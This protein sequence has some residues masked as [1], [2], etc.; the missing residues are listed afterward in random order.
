M[1]EG[2]KRVEYLDFAKGIGVILVIMG[3]MPSIVPN[4]IRM[5]IFSF[6]MP[7]FFVIAGYFA[8]VPNDIEGVI[9]AVRKKTL[10]LLVEGYIAFALCFLGLDIIFLRLDQET[11]RKSIYG[12]FSG[13]IDRIYWFFLSLYVVSILFLFLTRVVKKYNALLLIAALFA[14]ISIGLRTVEINCFRIGSSLYAFGFYCIGYI[15]KEKNTIDYLYSRKYCA[16]ISLAVS[17]F[18]AMFSLRMSPSILDINNNFSI[19]IA[20][21]YVLA[22][23][24]TWTVIFLSR[25]LCEKTGQVFIIKTLVFIGM[26]SFLFFPIT[27]YLPDLFRN[28]LN[29]NS[30]IV[31]I[32]AYIVAVVIVSCLVFLRRIVFIVKE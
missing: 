6:H 8:V 10:R 2:A 27:N 32:L 1:N 13:T 23:C 21:N 14:I 19:D 7:L 28:A 25:F 9:R 31:K 4:G 3:H 5:W 15:V 16:L 22:I 20:L 29:T 18:G 30:I 12:I 17:V 24:G 11:I 26:N